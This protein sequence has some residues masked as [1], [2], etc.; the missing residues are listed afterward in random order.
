MPV[1][2]VHIVLCYARQRGVVV[3]ESDDGISQL[4]TTRWRQE[5]VHVDTFKDLNFQ[6]VNKLNKHHKHNMCA[7][8]KKHVLFYSQTMVAGKKNASWQFKVLIHKTS[9]AV[10]NIWICGVMDITFPCT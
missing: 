6:S 4:A 9:Y 5:I 2:K 10:L 1:G 8:K 3:K 7:K